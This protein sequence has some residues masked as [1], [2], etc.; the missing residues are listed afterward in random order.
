MEAI[1]HRHHQ[2]V[3][4]ATARRRVRLYGCA[5]CGN[6]DR[7]VA[8]GS[9]VPSRAIADAGGQGVGI[10]VFATGGDV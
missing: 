9:N 7:I 4:D 6:G 1:G 10:R 8:T 5:A 2:R 3:R